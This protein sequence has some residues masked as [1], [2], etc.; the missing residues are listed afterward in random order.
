ME[1]FT[2]TADFW[3]RYFTTSYT[4]FKSSNRHQRWLVLPPDWTLVPGSPSL[5]LVLSVRGPA[6][7]GLFGIWS[8]TQVN[9]SV[10]SQLLRMNQSS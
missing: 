2:I 1:D 5:E 7:D 4:I 3:V 9:V 6:Q 8:Q 10:R